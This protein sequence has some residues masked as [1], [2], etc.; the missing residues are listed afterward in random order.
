M[1]IQRMNTQRNSVQRKR[2]QSKDL[3][4]RP[5]F[6]RLL[7]PLGAIHRSNHLKMTFCLPRFRFLCLLTALFVL[8]AAANEVDADEF[9]W[10]Q[11]SEQGYFQVT[12]D[13]Q[14]TD[15][16]EINQFL[17]WILTV[18]TVA[19]EVVTPARI[20]V[21]GGMPMHG[22]G[23]PTQPQISEY[24]G[25]GRYLMKGLKFSMNGRWELTFE[26]QSKDLRD[27]VVFDF[28]IDY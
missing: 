28:I 4:S 24:L 17:E 3:K 25:D 21:A 1:R 15:S 5:V 10:Q 14:A 8:P 27:K 9:V 16:V 20:T 19:G 6:G 22:H 23:L 2:C 13:S 18:K 12:L 11:S 26:I 7:A